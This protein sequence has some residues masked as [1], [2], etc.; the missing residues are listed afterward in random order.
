MD[1]AGTDDNKRQFPNIP[2]SVLSLLGISA[3]SYLV[4]KGIQFSNDEG[5]RERPPSVD[6]TPLAPQM[7]PG[8]SQQFTAAVDRADDNTV[9]W[10]INPQVGTISPAGLY[11]APASIGQSEIHIEVQAVSVVDPKGVGKAS[12]KLMQ[13]PAPGTTAAATTTPAP[14]TTV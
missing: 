1:S 2:G 9:S 14:T 4:S 13:P 7:H 11:T 8:Q 10:S 3:S 6:V 12:I 5:V